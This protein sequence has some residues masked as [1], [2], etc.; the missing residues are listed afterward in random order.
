MKP[1]DVTAALDALKGREVRVNGE[2]V[3]SA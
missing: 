3:F 1:G 2:V